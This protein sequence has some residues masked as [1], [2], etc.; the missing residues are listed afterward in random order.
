MLVT[1]KRLLL[2]SE[3]SEYCIRVLIF[4]KTLKLLIQCTPLISVSSAL[5]LYT[6]TSEC[7]FSILSSINFQ[8]VRFRPG[9]FVSK[10][11]ASSV[12]DHFLHSCDL[13]VE[14]WGDIVG[15]N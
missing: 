12:G 5:T 15:R 13:N 3:I 7:I 14:F 4:D 8:H 1:S 6:L 11:R 10:S 2:L 9:E